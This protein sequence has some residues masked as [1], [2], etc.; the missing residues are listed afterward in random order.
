M[1]SVLTKIYNFLEL[2]LVEKIIYSIRGDQIWGCSVMKEL[3]RSCLLWNTL[4][5][6]TIRQITDNFRCAV[7]S[8]WGIKENRLKEIAT[9]VRKH[10]ENLKIT[11]PSEIIIHNHWNVIEI[12]RVFKGWEYSYKNDHTPNKILLCY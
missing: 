3:I 2:A 1:L 5:G 6:R 8:D 12:Y 4:R 9:M 10:I 7:C 11:V